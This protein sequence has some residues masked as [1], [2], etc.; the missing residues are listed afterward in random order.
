M[1][2]PSSRMDIARITFAVIAICSLL[3]GCYALSAMMDLFCSYDIT[4]NLHLT[5][6]VYNVFDKEY[7]LWNR[8]RTAGAGNAVFSGS[9]SAAGIGRWS[10]PG[11]NARVT[12]AWS[13]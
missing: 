2:P 1:P 6:G 10:Q 4:K 13:F 8:V 7:Y 5:A 3:A 9:T 12:L 11:R